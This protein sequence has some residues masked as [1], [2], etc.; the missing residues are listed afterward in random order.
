[1]GGFVFFLL[2]AAALVAM[3]KAGQPAPVVIKVDAGMSKFWAAQAVEAN[4][5]MV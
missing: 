4:G 2:A 3:A 5:G 1:M